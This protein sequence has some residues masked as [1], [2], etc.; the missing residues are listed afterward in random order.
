MR[1]FLP[2]ISSWIVLS[3]SGCG[4]SGVPPTTSA[5][6]PT[7]PPIESSNPATNPPTTPPT[8]PAAP[9]AAYDPFA[10]QPDTS[11]G[12]TNISANLNAI[13]EHGTLPDACAAY[14]ADPNNRKKMLLCGKYM[15]FYESYGTLGAPTALIEYLLDNYPEPNLIGPGFA[16]QGMILDP[17]SP[18]GYP[19]G[20]APTRPIN[21]GMQALAFTCASCHFTQLP[22]GRYAVGG[23]N[24]DYDYGGQILAISLFPLMAANPEERDTH[25]PVATARIQPLLDAYDANPQRQA[26]LFAALAQILPFADGIPTLTQADENQYASWLP[27]TQDFAIAPLPLND[28]VYTIHR[29][30]NLWGLPDETETQQTGMTH[31]ML[32]W[33][34]SVFSLTNF[35]LSFVE[36]GGGEVDQ[37]PAE[38]LQPLVE[39]IYSLRAPNN[40]NPPPAADIAAG[41]TLFTSQGCID[42]HGAPR[43]ASH[44]WISYAETGVDAAMDLWFDGEDNDDQLCCGIVQG[45]GDALTNGTKAPRLNGVWSTGKLLH[46]GSVNGLDDLFCL[47]GPRGNITRPGFGNG[48]HL[49][50]CNG[51]SDA[52]KQH[53]IAYLNS[54]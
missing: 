51:L 44:H 47:N 52:D 16:A 8:T 19:L 15:F 12:L 23:G 6:A 46:N 13:L 31:A 32:G 49:Y 53:L 24:L 21:T 30:H 36:L 27:G 5:A 18:N 50:T 2:L 9:P 39:Y 28:Q 26:A 11:E 41:K 38:K 10:P 54:L 7:E 45:V 20:L 48:G 33:G 25:D 40:P 29:I 1:I 35:A 43:G 22:D 34:A 42:C 17:N 14:E 3:L 37:W 4:S